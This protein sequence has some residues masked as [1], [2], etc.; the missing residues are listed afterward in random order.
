MERQNALH[1]VPPE[2]VRLVVADMGWTPQRLVVP[3]ALRWL[4]P[5]GTIVTLVKPHYERSDR[6]RRLPREGILTPE[7]A[8]AETARVLGL[9][10]DFGARVLGV[11]ASPVVG[12]ASK[13]K[14]GRGNPESLA[15]LAPIDAR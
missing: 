7:E 5:G 12:G 3:A 8:E 6:D 2:P 4:I 13:N 14:S 9:M 15:H 11:V 1:A 10:P